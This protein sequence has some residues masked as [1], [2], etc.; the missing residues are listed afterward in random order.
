MA[1]AIWYNRQ[2]ATQFAAEFSRS[3]LPPADRNFA[4]SVWT[5]GLNTWNS[6]PV[7]TDYHAGGDPDC[8]RIVI[9]GK[10]QGQTIT[11][12]QFRDFLYRQAALGGPG[13]GYLQALADDMNNGSDGAQEPYP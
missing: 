3:D 12:Q 8:R 5:A 11:L 1:F 13:A 2:D 4:Q 9:D 10:H 7:E 6:A